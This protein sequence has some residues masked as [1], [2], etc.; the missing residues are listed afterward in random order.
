MIR[1]KVQPRP[2]RRFRALLVHP[3]FTSESFW[4]YRATC[5]LA[6]ARYAAIPLGL[7]TVAALLPRTWDFR[8]VDCNVRRL[9]DRDL[10]WADL[11]FVGG[12]I[13]QQLEILKVIERARIGYLVMNGLGVVFL[14]VALG[15]LVSELDIGVVSAINVVLALF[16]N[17]LLLSLIATDV[18]LVG[19]DRARS[20]RHDP[21]AAEFRAAYEAELSDFVSSRRR[22]VAPGGGD[23][24]RRPEGG[25]P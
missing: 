14:V 7:L 15:D 2:G 23:I 12:M 9:D 5:K 18:L 21:Q 3:E 16:A 8:V 1:P 22:T 24:G 19:L 13:S 4:N 25:S 17:V 20:V 10:R 6:G 11:V